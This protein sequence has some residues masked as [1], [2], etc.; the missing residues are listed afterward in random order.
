MRVLDVEDKEASSKINLKDV[1]WW[2]SLKEVCKLRVL[3]TIGL[4]K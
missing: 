3:V 2:M 4:S 1:S